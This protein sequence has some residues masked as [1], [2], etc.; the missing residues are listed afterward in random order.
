MEKVTRITIAKPDDFHVHVRDGDLMRAVLPFTSRT[1][2][3]AVIMPNLTPPITSLAL[4]DEYRKQIIDALPDESQ[5]MPLMTHYLNAQSDVDDIA[6][7]FRE[8]VYSAVKYYPS[9]ATTNSQ[10]GVSDIKMAYPV[11]E[12]MQKIGMPLLVHGEIVD[13]STDIFDKEAVFI[14]K[15]LRQIVKGFPELRI[16]FEHITTKEAA[17]FVRDQP[18]NIAATIT[19]QHLMLN[20]NAIFNKGIRPHMYCLPI[21]KREKHRLALRKAATSGSGKYFLGTDSAP[22]IVGRKENDCGCAGMFNAPYALECY[23]QVFDEEDALDKLEQFTSLNGANFY[24]LAINK[25]QITLEKRPVD[26]VDYLTVSEGE[27]VKI[28]VPDDGI[29]WQIIDL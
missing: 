28:F 19:P 10:F 29:Q 20:R 8:G 17:D 27:T 9:G 21:L 24:Q 3:R 25:N 5:F 13:D 15:I 11:L 23:T 12:T 26:H 18:D 6:H 1:F 2:S 16:V 22:H 7:G 14:D 4:A